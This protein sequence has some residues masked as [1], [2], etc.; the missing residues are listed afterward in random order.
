MYKTLTNKQL[1]KRVW[2]SFGIF[3][4]GL[5]LHVVSVRFLKY[6]IGELLA[7]WVDGFIQTGITIGSLHYLLWLYCKVDEYQQSGKEKYN[8]TNFLVCGVVSLVF[9]VMFI[10]HIVAWYN[11]SSLLSKSGW[12]LFIYSTVMIIVFT[13]FNTFFVYLKTES[14][15][16]IDGDDLDLELEKEE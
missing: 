16:K 7:V 10:V 4:A 11:G 3:M 12:M 15:F 5:L 14:I 2:F 8:R 9:W 6:Q 1:M 13:L